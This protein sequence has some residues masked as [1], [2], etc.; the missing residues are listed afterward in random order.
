MDGYLVCYHFGVTMNNAV[1]NIHVHD[2]FINS[3]EL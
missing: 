3:L 1:L 2:T